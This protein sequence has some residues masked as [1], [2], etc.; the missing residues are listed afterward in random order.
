[1]RYFELNDDVEIPGRWDLGSPRNQQGEEVD[2]WQFSSG[3]P[4]DIESPL[5]VPLRAGDGRALDFTEAG[6]GTPIVSTRIGAVFE[7]VAPKDV[8]LIPV[9]VEAHP[10]QFYIL[11]CTRVVK[12]IDDEASEE[13]Q[14]WTPEDGMPE[15][16]GTY[17]S[18]FG[19]RIDPAK[20]G[21]AQVFRPWGW[22]GALI[23]SEELKD[24]LERAG[25]VGVRFTEVTGPSAINQ[26][27]RARDQKWRERLRQA[28][29]AREEVWSTLGKLDEEAIVPIVVGGAW[30][31]R[32]Q[33][34][35]VIHRSGGRRLLV[36]DGLSDPFW[37]KNEPSVGF[38]LEL[39]LETDEPQDDVMGDWPLLLLERVGDEVAEH[40]RVRERVMAG[41]FSMEV[42]G[43]DMPR[44]L[45]TE[46]GR[47][48]V[49]LGVASS[50]LPMD[51]AIPS[52]EVRLVT[53][54][55]LRPAELAYLMEHG[56]QAYVELAR[57]FVE[58]GEEHL[59]RVRR[60]PLIPG[61]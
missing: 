26:E 18:V 47:V 58:S 51:F 41:L 16:V 27:E 5:K 6:V 45:V 1:M 35:R 33:V 38:G 36:T 55:A 43:K 49:L 60:R 39:A 34:W 37:G 17:S 54:K 32:R 19:M 50:S 22:T 30:P 7:E 61:S 29:T 2:P 24:A 53:V 11:V 12:C 48:A 40:E 14:Y 8:Q 15:K 9:E 10:G 21:N 56:K 23:V 52:G 46:E 4:V 3:S 28:E 57:R 13:V 31:A 59:S 20:V 44:S 25:A 42:S